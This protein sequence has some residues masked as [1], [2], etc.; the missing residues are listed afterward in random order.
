MRQKIDD[1]ESKYEEAAIQKNHEDQCSRPI[2]INKSILDYKRMLSNYGKRLA[3][4]KKVIIRFANRGYTLNILNNNNINY[5]NN[6]NNYCYYFYYY[7]Y[8]CHYYYYYY[9]Y[10]RD[11]CKVDLSE[12][13]FPAD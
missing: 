11:L 10:Y 13:D 7:H 1:L 9:Y 5:N 6:N 4:E 8:H 2:N 12:L 3:K